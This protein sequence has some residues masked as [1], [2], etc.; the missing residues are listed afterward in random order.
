VPRFLG[1]EAKLVPSHV[2]AY[3]C[4]GRGCWID[5][6]HGDGNGLGF[7][8]VLLQA[9]GCTHLVSLRTKD[10]CLPSL[11]L[12]ADGRLAMSCLVT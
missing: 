3:R 9:A 8:G 7:G 6:G 12:L 11:P 5:L 2:G 1:F 10:V 4:P